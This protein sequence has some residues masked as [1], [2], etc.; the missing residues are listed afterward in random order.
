MSSADGHDGG[1]NDN[2]ASGL[3]GFRPHG[4][5]ETMLFESLVHQLIEKGVLTKNDA[6]SIVQTVA[7]VK[8]GRLAGSDGAPGTDNELALLRRLYTSFE[9]LLDRSA[10]VT[11]FPANVR[12]LRPPLHGNAPEFPED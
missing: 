2:S 7:Q 5:V 10:L 6:L 4:T 11:G 1:H 3:N 9:A 12:Q 8:Q